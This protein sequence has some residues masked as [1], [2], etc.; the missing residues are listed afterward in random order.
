MSRR[1]IQKLRT[2]SD[3]SKPGSQ[4]TQADREFLNKLLPAG[5]GSFFSPHRGKYPG[6]QIKCPKC[7]AVPPAHLK[8]NRRW[9]WLAVHEVA[10]HRR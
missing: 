6:L 3:S 7:G 2:Q 10:E 9:R 1:S 8:G 5:W 4:L